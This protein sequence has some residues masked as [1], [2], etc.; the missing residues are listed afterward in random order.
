MHKYLRIIDAYVAI[1]EGVT[2]QDEAGRLW[3]IV[4]MLRY[5]IQ[6]SREGADRIGVPLYVRNDNIR[7]RLVKLIA[8]CSALDIPDRST[9]EYELEKLK[10]RFKAELISAKIRKNR[11]GPSSTYTINYK[12]RETEII[13]IF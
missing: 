13:R 4:W 12:V 3:D 10:R 6:N 8:V 2:G 11:P 7:A 9:A 1:P 5:A